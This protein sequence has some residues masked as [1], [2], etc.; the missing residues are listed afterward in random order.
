MTA[1]APANR[2]PP[3]RSGKPAID[4]PQSGET[5][6]IGGKIVPT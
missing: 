1:L 5:P 6:E 4:A 3:A 2:P